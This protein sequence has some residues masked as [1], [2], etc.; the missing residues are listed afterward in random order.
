MG[1]ISANPIDLLDIK[2]LYR[3]PIRP[4]LM[5]AT[6]LNLTRHYF[7]KPEY[8]VTPRFKGKPNR[9]I[10]PSEQDSVKIVSVAA[11]EKVTTDKIPLIALRRLEWVP[12]QLGLGDGIINSSTKNTFTTSFQGGHAFF[13]RSTE[14]GEVEYLVEEV[15]NLLI[16]YQTVIRR[17]LNLAQFNVSLV[18]KVSMSVY[19]KEYYTCPV[20]VKYTWVESWSYDKS[21]D[22]IVGVIDRTLMEI[23]WPP[24]AIDK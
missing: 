11:R 7:T 17:L 15:M 1:D 8:L 6:L 10:T 16:R 12:V 2:Y 24:P 14:M 18:E 13:C 3:Y 9:G 20:T 21:I 4:N 23:G 22:D 19:H 5:N